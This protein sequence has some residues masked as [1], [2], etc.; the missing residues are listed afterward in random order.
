MGQE[1]D[2]NDRIKYLL[3]LLRN[4]QRFQ[5]IISILKTRQWF[6]DKFRITE[7]NDKVILN[8]NHVFRAIQITS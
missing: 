8:F 1:T 5:W 2:F 7:G 4:S 6:V 3:S